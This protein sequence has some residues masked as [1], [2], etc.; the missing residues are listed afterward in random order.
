M[1]GVWFILQEEVKNQ[2]I[3]EENQQ[4]VKVAS[5]KTKAM[6]IGFYDHFLLAYLMV[7]SATATTLQSCRYGGL[8]QERRFSES[9]ERQDGK[10]NRETGRDIL[11]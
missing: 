3:R 9:V 7:P 1:L 5:A 10:G 11:N 6:V 8:Q 2:R 4:T